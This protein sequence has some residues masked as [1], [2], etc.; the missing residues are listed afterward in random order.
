MCHDSGTAKCFVT[1]NIVLSD[2]YIYI[3]VW[4]SQ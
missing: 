4:I 2:I 1:I 3:F